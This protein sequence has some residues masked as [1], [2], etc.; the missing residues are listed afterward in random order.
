MRY[1]E[2]FEVLGIIKYQASNG[3]NVYEGGRGKNATKGQVDGGNIGDYVLRLKN[4]GF[5]N[6]ISVMSPEEWE[7]LSK[8]EKEAEALGV[9]E[10]K[11][12]EEL[13]AELVKTK[14]R[15][16]ELEKASRGE[17]EHKSDVEVLPAVE[18]ELLDNEGDK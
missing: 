8:D 14:R 12:I 5:I 7:A 4:G 2:Q 18:P 17:K 1:K 10:F 6:S 11:T 9:V 16:L 13:K 3:L 15:L